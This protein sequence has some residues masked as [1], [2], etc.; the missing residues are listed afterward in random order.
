MEAVSLNFLQIILN[1]NLEIM[2]PIKIV[3]QYKEIPNYIM[4]LV[5]SSNENDSDWW[6]KEFG[7]YVENV[8]GIM[9]FDNRHIDEDSENK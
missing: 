7:N 3:G 2:I 6:E 4:A 9:I 8:N 5:K 1:Q